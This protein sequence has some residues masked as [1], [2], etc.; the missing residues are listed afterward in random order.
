MSFLLASALKRILEPK[1][2]VPIATIMETFLAT[3]YLRT[4]TG[5]NLQQVIYLFSFLIFRCR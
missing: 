3:G 1:K 2:T 4:T 5:L